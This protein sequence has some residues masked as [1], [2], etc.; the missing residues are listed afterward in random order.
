MQEPDDAHKFERPD[1]GESEPADVTRDLAL[2]CDYLLYSSY[3][4]FRKN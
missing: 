1:A 4:T 3:R 2:G